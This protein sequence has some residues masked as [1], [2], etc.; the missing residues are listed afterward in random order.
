MKPRVLLLYYSFTNQTRRVSEAMAEVFRE[1]G[2]EA[3][4]CEIEF[5]DPKHRIEFPFRPFWP[6][7][8]RWLIPQ[9]LG[10]TGEI[11][12][13][14]RVIEQDYDLVCLGSPTWWLHPAMPIVSFLKSR[15]AYQLLNGRR[16]VVFAV[17]RAIWWNNVRVV[18]KSAK[19]AGGCF[20]KA[21]AF[22]FRGNQVQTALTFLNYM[23][24]EQNRDRYLGVRIYEFGIPDE[25]IEK[26]RSLARDLARSQKSEA[27]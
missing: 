19:R 18:K 10:R 2:W 1:E 9:F 21:A 16:F 13:D 7:L 12:V 23:Q 4:V 5:I 6:R 14:E 11:H 26:A 3:H 15:S 17:C 22:C 24:T 20:V 27:S 25:G 8:M